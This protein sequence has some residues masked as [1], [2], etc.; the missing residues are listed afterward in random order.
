MLRMGRTNKRTL[1]GP[2]RLA[3][4]TREL[5]SKVEELYE[6]WFRVWQDAVMP[7]LIFQPKWYDI[8]RDLQEG[9]LVYFQKSESKLD[10]KWQ[11]G[12][13]EQIVRGRD[14]KI[15]KVILK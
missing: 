8:D 13:V 10:N 15:R 11:V 3:R 2:F 12:K 9:D 6:A 14:Q 4:G 7:N 5:L 1:D